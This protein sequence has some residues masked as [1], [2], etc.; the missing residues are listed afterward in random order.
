VDNEGAAEVLAEAEISAPHGVVGPTLVNETLGWRVRLLT[1]VD[2]G[3]TARVWRDGEGELRAAISAADGTTRSVPGAEILAGPLGVQAWVPAD[4]E[5]PVANGS[6]RPGGLQ[7]NDPPSPRLVLLRARHAGAAAQALTLRVDEA[8]L[9]PGSEPVAADGSDARLAGRLR[10]KEGAYHLVDADED[11]LAE[12]RAGP[13]VDLAAHRARAVAVEGPLHA[14]EP[15]PMVVQEV[16]NLFDVTLRATTDEGEAVEERYPGVTIGLGRAGRE[17][18]AWQINAGPRASRLVAAE[19]L[20]KGTALRL[21]RGRS[22]WRYLDCD[23]SRFDQVHFDAVRFAGGRCHDRVV[24]DVSRFA[25]VPPDPVAAV[26]AS[27]DPSL[28]PPA[29]VVL[30]WANYRPG[31]FRVHLPVDLP[32]RFGGRFNESRFGQAEDA[33][34][35][36]PGA[37]TEPPDDEAYLVDLINAQSSLVEAAVVARVPLGWEAATIPY[38]KPQYLSLGAEDAAARLYLT[39]AGIEGYIELQAREAGTW[40]NE[41]AVTARRSGPAMYDVSIIYEGIRFENARQVVLG[42]GP[43]SPPPAC[44]KGKTAAAAPDTEEGE[45]PALIQTLLRPGPIGV[46]QAKAAGI[47]ADVTRERTEPVRERTQLTQGGTDG[48]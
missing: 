7:L 35:L 47:R 40:G 13:G 16:S 30:R 38:R 39:E 45:L 2:A 36:Y 14:G 29:E 44:Q 25:H 4:G 17:S 10:E 11:V 6:E 48:N 28:A 27:S 20:D 3:G 24:F 8:A 26:F 1:V 23:A 41:I 46:L 31:A 22:R 33:P 34:E 18:L 15:P 5:W 42:L 21:P 32:A 9:E 37:V 19:E 12:L 43:A